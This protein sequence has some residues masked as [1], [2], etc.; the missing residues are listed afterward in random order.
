MM[1]DAELYYAIGACCPMNN[2]LFIKKKIYSV[3]I[4]FINRKINSKVRW[5]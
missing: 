3:A 1:Q 5:K 2:F 4:I